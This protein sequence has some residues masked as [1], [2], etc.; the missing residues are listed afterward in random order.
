MN[1][2]LE[3]VGVVVLGMVLGCMFAYG[4]LGSFI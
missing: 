4:L 3:V 2:F 1:Q